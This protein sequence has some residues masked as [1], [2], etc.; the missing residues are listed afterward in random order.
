MV[1]DMQSLKVTPE[2]RASG[3][4]ISPNDK[5]PKTRKCMFI[6]FPKPLKDTSRGTRVSFIFSLI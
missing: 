2:L 1:K 5:S 6:T 4:S 3:I